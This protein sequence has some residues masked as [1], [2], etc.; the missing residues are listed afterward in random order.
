VNEQDRKWY[1]ID[2]EG[3][4]LGRLASK[5]AHILRGKNKVTFTPH[6]DLGDHVIIINATKVR[7]TGKKAQQKTYY[8]NTGYPGGLRSA[9]Y[10]KLMQEK[11]LWILEHA[12]KGM[13]PHNRLGRQML[14][15]L[16]LYESDQ[17]PHIAQK[18]E[19]LE[20]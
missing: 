16:R 6:L 5:V 2:A 20:L 14:K 10:N 11:P 17:H 9:T 4:I 13:L 1:L 15:K 18:P 12:I 8:R 3:K 19:K 7:V